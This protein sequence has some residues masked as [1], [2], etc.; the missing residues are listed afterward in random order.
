MRRK[1]QGRSDY[2]FGNQPDRQGLVYGAEGEKSAT[3]ERGVTGGAGLSGLFGA[4]NKRDETDKTNQ[5][6][7]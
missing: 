3:G 2:P 5:I 4:M 6:D 1:T 7:T